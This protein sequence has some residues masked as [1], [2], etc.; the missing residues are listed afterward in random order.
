MPSQPDSETTTVPCGYHGLVARSAANGLLLAALMG[1]IVHL[2]VR[3]RFR[4]LSTAFYATPWPVI[5]F[6][7]GLSGFVFFCQR[8]RWRGL[9]A[10]CLAVAALAG[11]VTCHVC[12]NRPVDCANRVRVVLWNA[13]WGRLGKD[14]V[15]VRL[16][17]TRADLIGI[18]ESGATRE[19]WQQ[20][21]PQRQIVTGRGGLL[22]IAKGRIRQWQRGSLGGCGRYLSFQW[23]YEGREVA[24]LLVD[25]RSSPFRSRAPAFDA[26]A[27]LAADAGDKPLILMGDF[28]TPIDSIYMDALRQKLAHVF[29]SAGR[30]PF[31]S[32]PVPCPVMALDH[33]WVSPH[34]RP[35]AAQY[36]ATLC[37]DHCLLH[38]DLQPPAQHGAL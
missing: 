9:L 5:L 28:N 35:A 34:L 4:F 12:W 17:E 37:S 11:F 21:F 15:M 38:V 18:V 3:D 10:V 24:G 26:I 25:I 8:R 13:C 22:L 6:L 14:R 16:E 33:V 1:F 23:H 7:A 2:T 27:K 29:E 20:A 36:R 31:L 19:E 32:W 30:G